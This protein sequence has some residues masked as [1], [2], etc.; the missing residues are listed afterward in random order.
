MIKPSGDVSSVNGSTNF[1]GGEDYFLYDRNRTNN[2]PLLYQ[3]L[4]A[5]AK[6]YIVIWDPHYQL[7]CDRLFCDMKNNDIHVEVLTICQGYE[8]R[9]DIMN[10]ANRILSAI[11]K[12]AVPKCM[13]TVNALKYL[14]DERLTWLPDWHD[15][16]LIVDGEVYLVGT[17]MDAQASRTGSFG[18]MRVTETK[19]KNLVIDAYMKYR[20]R[21]K[22]ESLPLCNGYKCIVK[23]GYVK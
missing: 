12:N 20:D 3:Q 21:I 13:V 5:Q 8:S 22:D 15:R 16:Y 19:D 9:N 11:D 14:W 6:D 23:R 17:S 4:L 1:V 7:D 10:F 2:Y 18:I